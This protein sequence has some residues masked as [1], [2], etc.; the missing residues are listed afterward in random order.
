[1]LTVADMS[2]NHGKSNN[3][4]YERSLVVMWVVSI[5]ATESKQLIYYDF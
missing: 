1:M 4:L 5:Q 3:V 2:K